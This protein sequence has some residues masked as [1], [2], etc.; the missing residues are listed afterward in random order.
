MK[1][2]KAPLRQASWLAMQLYVYSRNVPFRSANSRVVP[3]TRSYSVIATACAFWYRNSKK[4]YSLYIFSYTYILKVQKYMVPRI[5][6]FLPKYKF[7]EKLFDSAQNLQKLW[8][9]SY[10]Y[11]LKVLAQPDKFLLNKIL[12]KVFASFWNLWLFRKYINFQ[13]LFIC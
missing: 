8:P 6:R 5:C 2:E 11:F 10:H 3:M 13:N 4:V 9:T 12:R 1:K 7:N